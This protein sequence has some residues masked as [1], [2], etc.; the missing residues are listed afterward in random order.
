MRK[1]S[2]LEIEIL[3]KYFRRA[4]RR[5]GYSHEG[6]AYKTRQLV[7]LIAANTPQPEAGRHSLHI[8]AIADGIAERQPEETVHA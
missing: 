6:A 3:G 5:I 1:R 4:Y 2:P 8:Q 7:P